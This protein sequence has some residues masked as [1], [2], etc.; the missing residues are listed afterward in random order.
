[1]L[2]LPGGDLAY[3]TTLTW[4]PVDRDDDAFDLLL[5]KV[6][7][8]LESMTPPEASPSCAW[9]KLRPVPLIDHETAWTGND[10]SASAGASC[11]V[12]AGYFEGAAFA[13]LEH[14]RPV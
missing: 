7:E 6:A 9:C 3:R 12:A 5:P 1:M 13:R 8:M 2:R 10:H 4:I 14:R 11:P